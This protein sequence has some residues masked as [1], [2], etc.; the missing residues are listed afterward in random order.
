MAAC[1]LQ[2]AKAWL[3]DN[4]PEAAL[5]MGLASPEAL[6]AV[7]AARLADSSQ[8]GHG[9]DATRYAREALTASPVDERALRVLA[10]EADRNG[11]LT[12]ARMLMVIANRW[13]R[14][15]L[16]TQSWLFQQA[17]FEGDWTSASLHADALLRRDDR[18][19]TLVFPMMIRAL[20]NPAAVAPFVERVAESAN[21]RGPFLVELS[22]RAA[23]PADAA[24]VLLALAATP[25]PPR[26]EESAYLINRYVA[27]GDFVG[28]RDLWTRLLPHDAPDNTL[29]YDGDFR[30]APGAA[31]FNWRL[32]QS[33]GATAEMLPAADGRPALHVVSPAEKNVAA[34]EQ[35][36]T[37][38]PGAYRLSGMAL[39]EPGRSGDL[40]TWRLTC[41]T[42]GDADAAEARQSS[43]AAG[44]RAFAV[45]FRIPDHGCGAQWLRL[46][47]LA[48]LGLEPAEAW[49][50]GINITPLGK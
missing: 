3:A 2:A 49:Y 15:D 37:L 9:A 21:W 44:W 42:Q 23:A 17:L 39:V 16:F 12:P 28:A 32:I 24:R 45:N 26:N 19:E 29:V 14:R 11:G 40:F 43:G 1:G 4:S 36:L 10:L 48:H 38:P 18:L 34:T 25:T 5:A 30:P 35:L 20:H 13:S 47:G 6:S 33:D 46:E 22:R 31:P 41:V 7:A 8:P 27:Q 50:R